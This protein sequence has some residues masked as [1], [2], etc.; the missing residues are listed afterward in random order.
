[1][2]DAIMQCV[3]QREKIRSMWRRILGGVGRC[4]SGLCEKRETEQTSFLNNL[5]A[6]PNLTEPDTWTFSFYLCYLL[7]ICLNLSKWSRTVTT[8]PTTSGM[9]PVAVSRV[10]QCAARR[11]ESALSGCGATAG[12][13]PWLLLTYFRFWLINFSHFV[14]LYAGIF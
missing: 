2:T 10:L 14:V 9:K 12:E 5:W 4:H 6:K 11:K 7:V 13:S 8:P 1:M 3:R